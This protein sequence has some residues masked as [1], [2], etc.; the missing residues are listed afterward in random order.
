MEGAVYA[1]FLIFAVSPGKPLAFAQGSKSREEG[2]TRG[3]QVTV[4]V[5]VNATLEVLICPAGTK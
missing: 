4:G 3:Q 1:C 5:S 2:V